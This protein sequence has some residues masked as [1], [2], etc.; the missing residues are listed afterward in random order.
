MKAKL[1]CL[2]LAAML[3]MVVSAQGLAQTVAR[4]GNDKMY[5]GIGVQRF[6][7]SEDY[8][9]DAQPLQADLM[10][11]ANIHPYFGVE[12]HVGGNI[13]EDDN[14]AR[15]TATLNDYRGNTL[16]LQPL[17]S[18]KAE[19]KVPV[20]ASFFAKPK[21]SLGPIELYAL[22]GLAYTQVNRTISGEFNATYI[23]ST[24]AVTLINPYTQDITSRRKSLGFAY[25]GGAAIELGSLRIS[26]A[27]VNYGK[28]ESKGHPCYSQSS[29]NITC[30]NLF[31]ENTLSGLQV[32]LSWLF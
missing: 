13:Q 3:G 19:V 17:P 27:Y 24:G 6:T 8:F 1:G 14:P 10:F 15:V 26:G 7:F 16:V 9:P 31:A 11:G 23:S 20:Q 29:T 4:G 12:M 2:S 21:V 30:D 5:A 22:G 28:T 18:T 32:D 25:G